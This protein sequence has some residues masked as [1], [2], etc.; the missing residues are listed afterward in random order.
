MV[1]HIEVEGGCELK[2]IHIEGHPQMAPAPIYVQQPAQ[3]YVQQP[4]VQTV[5]APPQTVVVE[6]HH[7]NPAGAMVAGA[8]MGAAIA[9]I[10]RPHHGPVIVEPR[11]HGPVVVE[12]GRRHHGPVVV[13]RGFGHRR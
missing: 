9:D 5:V 4:Y 3:V 13:E 7:R 11:R 10:T 12:T 6:E 8:V 2:H 1:N